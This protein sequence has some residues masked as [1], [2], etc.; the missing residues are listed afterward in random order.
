MSKQTAVEWLLHYMSEAKG[1]EM[2][3]GEWIR[4]IDLVEKMM[5]TQ[6]INAWEDGHCFQ[7]Y[8]PRKK[9]GDNYYTN[10]Y[11]GDHE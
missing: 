6:I 5:K 1:R 11:G 9:N 3:E 2:E 10:T 7:H 4:V 8:D